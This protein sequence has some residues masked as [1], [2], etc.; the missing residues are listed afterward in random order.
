[1]TSFQPKLKSRRTIEA[2][3]KYDVL[4]KPL[5]LGHVPLDELP[6][7]EP[8]IR[9]GNSN[10]ER[11][12]TKY[13]DVLV[14]IVR[15][16]PI[17][18][19][20]STAR[21]NSD[22]H[23]TTTGGTHRESDHLLPSNVIGSGRKMQITPDDPH[24]T[25]AMESKEFP[26]L[27][28]TVHINMAVA[29]GDLVLKTPQNRADMFDRE[30]Y[31]RGFPFNRLRV[32]GLSEHSTR[33]QPPKQEYARIYSIWKRKQHKIARKEAMKDFES[34]DSS[35]TK[36]PGRNSENQLEIS[37]SST[38]NRGGFG[39]GGPKT[40]G[41]SNNRF[42]VL[43]SLSEQGSADDAADT[44]SD[45]SSRGTANDYNQYTTQPHTIDRA[46]PSFAHVARN[47]TPRSPHG[48]STA[49]TGPKPSVGKPPSVTN[50]TSPTNKPASTT[51]PCA[52]PKTPTTRSNPPAGAPKTAPT[53]KNKSPAPTDPSTKTINKHTPQPPRTAI[54][55]RVLATG[56][57]PPAQDPW[58][59]GAAL[60]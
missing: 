45:S 34:H 32:K 8:D 31:P 22:I 53:K 23:N 36:L 57:T 47:T 20:W 13:Q 37:G 2:L 48:N 21:I 9:F 41:G 19:G 25:L 17:E 42:A 49:I 35:G 58:Q 38:Y 59:K 18:G 40:P 44:C 51:A 10:M 11:L 56:C 33:L 15:T 5:L 14:N 29:P 6:Y 24:L 7:K 4:K 39:N 3:R 54:D 12:P 52:V 55:K 43:E 1:M 50:T 46:A 27:N 26:S 28:T 16:I 60:R 30:K